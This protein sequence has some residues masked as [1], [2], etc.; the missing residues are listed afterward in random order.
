MS[1]P[2][3]DLPPRILT[4]PPGPTAR[5]LAAR[6]RT[7]ESRN[8]TFLDADLPIFWERAR[9]SN[10]W[11][12]DGNRYVDLTA[13]F[14]VAVAGHRNR[15]VVQ[16]IRR[17]AARLGHGMG[18]VQP[19]TVKVKLLE[20]LARISPIP[21]PRTVLASSGAEAVEIALK[22]ARLGTGRPGVIAFTGAYHGL[23]YGALS[24]T[25]RDLFRA[26][27]EDQLNPHVI[28]LPYPH[29]YRPPPA[30]AAR[31]DD[32]GRAAIDVMEA[33]LDTPAGRRVG[34]VIVEPV[35]GR[36]GDVVPPA[37]FLR[38][39]AGL[40]R[41]HGLLLIVDEVYT[42]LG[43]IGRMFA[44]ESEGVVPDLL[45]LGKALSGTLPIAACLGSAEVM[46]A[47]PPSQGEAI[48]TSTFLGN[49]LACAAAL[50]SLAEI[51]RLRLPERAAAEG[52][53]WIRQLR[54]LGAGH[55]GV[56][57]VRGCGLMIGLDM[58]RDAASRAPDPERAGRVVTAALR[59]GWILLAGG[60]HGNVLS[61][62]PPLTIGR[63]LLEAGVDMLDRVLSDT[64]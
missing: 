62:S 55:A 39:L 21:A 23:T 30:L 13:G 50:A 64:S 59:Q 54:E 57:D 52:D 9:G 16:A 31:V 44:C 47:W 56:G 20:R 12:A 24:V 4:P 17:Q 58:V 7:V 48:H 63:H 8:V 53:R 1:R 3:T 2:H 25:D 19:P 32:L 27:F 22:T 28:R 6:L 35:Q 34:A 37:G 49:P 46:E 42:G 26:P 45:C 38:E 14:G 43:R 41:E 29:P 36:G 51:D 33:A 10:V 11:D 5:R 61:L 18:D 15:R 60:F 40:C